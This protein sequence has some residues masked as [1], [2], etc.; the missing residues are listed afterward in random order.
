MCTMQFYIVFLRKRYTCDKL[1]GMKTSVHLIIF[2]SLTKLYMD[3][4]K[5]LMPGIPN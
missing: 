3:S 2:A 5:H 1:L 4:N